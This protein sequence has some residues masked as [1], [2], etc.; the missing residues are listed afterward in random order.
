MGSGCSRCGW[1]WQD[2]SRAANRS[3]NN[4][5]IFRNTSTPGTISYDTRVDFPAVSFPR[6]V[7]FGDLDGD[8]KLD[9]AAP[10]NGGASVSVFRNTSSGPGNVGYAPKVDFTAGTTPQSVSIA[11][12]DRDGRLDMAVPNIGSNTLSV[13]RNTSSGIGSISFANKADFPTGVGPQTTGVV[14]FDGDGKP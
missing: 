2:R 6:Y 3:T 1:R 4:L 5:S 12:F 11:D 13:F 14:D 8:G 7:T 10:N 9:M